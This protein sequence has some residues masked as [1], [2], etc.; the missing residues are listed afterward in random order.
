MPDSVLVKD[1]NILGGVPIFRQTRV[2]FQA[3]LDYLEGGQTLDDFLKDFPT[4]SREA[5]I[6]ALEEAKALVVSRLG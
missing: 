3:L 6:A 2:P 4:V 5:A 1:E